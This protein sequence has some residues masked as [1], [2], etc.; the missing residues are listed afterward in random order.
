[1][2]KKK[3][4][5]VKGHWRTTA[6]GKEVWISPHTRSISV[7]GAGQAALLGLAANPF[8]KRFVFKFTPGFALCCMG[9]YYL[10]SWASAKWNNPWKFIQPNHDAIKNYV[11]NG[12]PRLPSPKAR[13]NPNGFSMKNFNKKIKKKKKSEKSYIPFNGVEALT[14]S[15]GMACWDLTH[16]YGSILG[17]LSKY[18]KKTGIERGKI[19]FV[20]GSGYDKKAE[21]TVGH[22]WIEIIIDEKPFVVD[23]ATTK[24]FHFVPIRKAYEKDKLDAYD[25]FSF[26]RGSIRKYRKEWWKE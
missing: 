22:I 23:T 1:M 19:R 15:K 9:G 18:P 26:D 11:L 7:S 21:E 4:V 10:Y 20:R 2:S 5:H 17:Y 12:G 13:K 14:T 16:L 24:P 25:M 3:S 6:S 8:F